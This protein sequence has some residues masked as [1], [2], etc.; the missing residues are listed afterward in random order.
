MSDRRHRWRS[1]GLAAGA[2]LLCLMFLALAFLSTV[3]MDATP[4]DLGGI[5][6]N[7]RAGWALALTGT[8]ALSVLSSLIGLVLA[9][10]GRS[11]R[12][13]ILWAITLVAIAMV[14]FFVI[15]D[16]HTVPCG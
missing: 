14:I 12:T 8:A 9:S 16:P 7:S 1:T 13:A 3:N 6:Q 10:L 11:P 15:P 5:C 2:L 4:G